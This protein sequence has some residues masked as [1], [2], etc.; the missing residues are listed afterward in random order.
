MLSQASKDILLKYVVQA[1]PSYVT[2]IFALPIGLYEELERMIN[3]YWWGKS[4]QSRRGIR[5]KNWSK[6]S[7][8]NINRV[9]DSESYMN[10]TLHYL[11][12]KFGN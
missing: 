3:S 2:S 10:L 12:S 9:W 6:L 4:G 5:W 11:P 8:S 7:R 1:L